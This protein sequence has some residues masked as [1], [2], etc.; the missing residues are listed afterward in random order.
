MIMPTWHEEAWAEQQEYEI[1]LGGNQTHLL[2]TPRSPSHDDDYNDA[3]Y[4]DDNYV[5]DDVD[6][7][8]DAD[9]VAVN[10]D[11]DYQFSL[12]TCVTVASLNSTGVT[13][14]LPLHAIVGKADN[15]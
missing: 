8:D 12:R 11:A 6:T 2:H 14:L 3:D 5:V 4:D 10:A 13:C 15:H 7:D 1:Q 9:D